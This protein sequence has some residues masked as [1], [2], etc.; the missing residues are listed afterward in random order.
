[1][2]SCSA[3]S[4][5]RHDAPAQYDLG[6]TLYPVLGGCCSDDCGAVGV[7]DVDAA[8]G[9]GCDDAGGVGGSDADADG[10]DRGSGDTDGAA[11]GS[12]NVDGADGDGKYGEGSDLA[13]WVALTLRFVRS[14]GARLSEQ[15]GH[16]ELAFA[17]TGSR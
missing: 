9:G 14:S 10:S 1:M 6:K 11:G 13:R 7:D 15:V 17:V 2:I 12:N 4:R 16:F 3:F 5:H 8:D